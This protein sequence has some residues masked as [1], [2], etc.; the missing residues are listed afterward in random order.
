MSSGNRKI[1]VWR[2]RWI[3]GAANATRQE[4]APAPWLRKAFTLDRLP[5]RA[6]LPLCGLGWHELY[7]NGVKADDR[8]L[9][10]VV[11]QFDRHVG[12][13]VYDVTR[14]LR[15]GPNTLVVVL[16]NGWYN[17]Q[18]A[19]V[20]NFATAPWRD[21]PKLCCD[22]ICDG[23]TV[24]SSDDSWRCRTGP[25]VFDALRNGET[26]D[27]RLEF[28]GVFEPEFD[29]A[30]W[31]PAVY[32]NPPGGI[33]EEETLEPCKVMQI[34]EPVGSHE[35]A[36]GVFT[37]DFGVN[38]TGWCEITVAGPA[39][40]TVKLEYS[41][42]VRD[43]MD[44]DRECIALYVKSGDFQTDRYLCKGT[45]KPETWHPRFTYHGF[46]YV[47]VSSSRSE[48]R[49]LAIRA[50]LIHNAFA[51]AGTFQSDSPMLNRLQELTLRSYCCNFTGIPTDCPH[52]EKN[53]WTGDAQLALATGFWNFD[54]ARATAHFA[55]ILA[56]TQRPSG[57]LPGIAPCAGWGYNWG[58]G[59]AWDI[60][61]FESADLSHRFTGSDALIRANYD[62]CARYLD[63]CR[64]MATDHLVAFGLGD[65]CHVD[66][67]RAAPVEL[68][69]SAYF[70]HAAMLMA[71]FATVCGRDP[72]EFT[73]LADAIRDRINARYYHGDGRYGS[74]EWTALAAML[75]FEIAAPAER[76]R[77]AE[78][79]AKAVR[80]NHHRADFG[81]LGAKFVPRVLADYG[82]VDDAFQLIVQ[83][84]FPGWGH[85]VAQGAT[86][87]WEDWHGLQ[88]QNHIMF[89]D[90]SAWMYEYPGGFSLRRSRPGLT[91]PYWKPFFPAGLNEVAATHRL[92]QGELRSAWR[93]EGDHIVYAVELPDGMAG[94]VELPDGAIHPV[95]GKRQF[96]VA[97]PP[98]GK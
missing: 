11:T 44:I 81:I 83:P 54:A 63:Y 19:E 8:V 61:L 74:G 85:W 4:I 79:L 84:E 92:A 12:Y 87:L 27:A 31:P 32:L 28:D 48:L 95:S 40:A 2:G 64:S 75:Y 17:C 73:E 62:H 76:P 50:H 18:T 91:H 34:I 7:V 37:I 1:H 25:I 71:E 38:L 66:P 20:W 30:G 82:Y 55:R 58:S 97:V 29:D 86:T 10:P 57:Q 15:K 69:S 68:T 78:R 65:W 93:R 94:T 13:I 96:T 33:P 77:V 41:E 47:R 36:P 24:L 56:D 5:V 16:G 21:R 46:R 51:P 3:G 43:D 9:A 70:Y 98:D 14:L 45:G 52:R 26:Y 42:R 60:Y 59:P 6:E 80:A 53:G 88:S 23:V 22:L 39:G 89:G 35:L 90:I 72:A 49:I 67:G